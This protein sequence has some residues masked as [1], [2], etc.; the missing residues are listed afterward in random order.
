MSTT[1]AIAVSGL[2]V[3]ELRLQV[4]ASNIVNALSDGPSQGSNGLTTF[5]AAYT[6]PHVKQI[7]TA[8]GGTSGSIGLVPP[9]YLHGFDPTAPHSGANGVVARPN[10]DLAGELVQQ[11]IARISFAANAQ[12]LRADAH[13]TAA[14]LDIKV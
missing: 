3:A 6:P 9:V 1:S 14:L 7:A 11:V 10:V 2:K 4:S 12:V 13:T 8:N 5:P